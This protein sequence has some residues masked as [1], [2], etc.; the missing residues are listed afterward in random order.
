MV[1]TEQV[2]VAAA[3]EEESPAA[4]G[5]NVISIEACTNS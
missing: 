3:A 2:A 5:K 1:M 4:L